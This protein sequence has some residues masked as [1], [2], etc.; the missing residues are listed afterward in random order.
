MRSFFSLSFMSLVLSFAGCGRPIEGRELSE[1]LSKGG[2]ADRT[3]EYDFGPVLA[4]GQLLKHSFLVRNHLEGVWKS[5]KVRL[6]P[7]A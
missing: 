1:L 6:R 5:G 4:E 2:P 3:N 7:A